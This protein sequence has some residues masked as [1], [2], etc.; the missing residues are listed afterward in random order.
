MR[1]LILIFLFFTIIIYC[2]CQPEFKA[3]APVSYDVFVVMG[4]SN[5]NCGRGLDYKLDASDYRI[6]QLGR[7]S[8]NDHQIIVAREPLDHFIRMDSCN[9]FAMTF[10]LM[11]LKRYKEPGREVLLLPCGEPGSS[12]RFRRW[13]KG[14]TLYNDVVERAKFV[15]NKFPG[16]KIKGFLWHQGETDVY[17]GRD[18]INLLDP[19]ITSIKRDISG[20]AGDS[21]P[22]IL[23]GMVPFWVD[24]LSGRK[25]TDSVI[26]ETPNRLP[27]TGYASA[28]EPFVIIKP[29][30]S[31][32]DIHFDAAGQR[33][34]GKRYFETY[35]KIR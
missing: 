3:D 18:Y 26:M 21:I 6:K 34:L 23:G 29:D 27:F 28:K 10:A 9:G 24:K 13:N 20:N 4:Q 25:I 33:E 22:F 5:T 8:G 2:S 35:E 31:I 11:Y 32:D 16:S 15:L 17:W 30:N 12:F 19:M 7:F 14:D 1:G